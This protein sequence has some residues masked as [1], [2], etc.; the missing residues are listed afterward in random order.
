MTVAMETL[1]DFITQ[2]VVSIFT[3]PFGSALHSYDYVSDG[4]PVVPTEAIVSGRLDPLKFPKI[5][6]EKAQELSR[7]SLNVG[8]LVFARRGAQAC[9]LS[10]MVD[11]ASHGAIAGTGTIV[12]RV[13]DPSQI[14]CKF[15]SLL[16]GSQDSVNWLK[17]HAV[18]ATMPNLNSSIIATLPVS[19]PAIEDQ[20]AI[21]AIISTLDDKIELSRRMNRTL[22]AMAQ[23]IFK[24]WFVDFEPVRAKATAKAAGA[25]SA[26]IERAAMAAI[27]GRSIEEAIAQEGY[28]D[29]LTNSNR[30]S[31][32]QTAALFPD[33]VQDSPL[34]EI[35]ARWNVVG[36]DKLATLD[37]TSVKP[38]NSPTKLWEHYSIPSFDAS[39]LPTWETGACIKSNKYLVKPG[40]I[41]AS[42]LNPQF[43]RTWWPPHFDKNAAICSTEFMQF[44]PVDP[45]EQ[46]FIYGLI[47]SAPFQ[48][49]I[50][51]RVTGSTGSRQ[52]AQPKQIATIS[53][54]DS[55][56]AIRRE[57]VRVT[58]PIYKK[59]NSGLLE[60]KTLGQLRDTL[61]PKLLSGKIQVPESEKRSS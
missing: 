47:T 31:L 49:G 53:V 8:D 38:F 12:A 50:G 23:A 19:I 54:L 32:A 22:E 20:Q 52:R 16:L 18:G 28:F 41:L 29:E 9:G 3:G 48:A 40:A 59:T 55:G 1:G 21:A 57:F 42:K 45:T 14:D 35:P 43:P 58:Q 26:A 46:A 17:H 5:T 36:F 13:N 25:D 7:Y 44:I 4:V 11:K 61:L 39:N 15:F 37:T 2:G 30:E 60:S 24:S 27:S 6:E 34:G 56:S 51:E 33:T 10:A